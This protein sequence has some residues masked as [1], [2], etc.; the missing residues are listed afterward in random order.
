MLIEERSTTDGWGKD[1]LTPL[2][3]G[4]AEVMPWV[5]QWHDQVD[6][7]F[8]A[9]P[10]R[11]YRAVLIEAVRPQ[12]LYAYLDDGML[13]RL[14][15]LMWLPVQLRKAWELKFRFMPRSAGLRLP[16]KGSGGTVFRVPVRPHLVNPAGIFGPFAT[17]ILPAHSTRKRM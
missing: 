2:L 7:S 13:R 8:G 12:D 17:T 4:L 10:A 3:A 16:D 9:S 14:W 5:R 15:A 6:S 1:K 11:E